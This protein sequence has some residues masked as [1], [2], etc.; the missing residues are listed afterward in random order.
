MIILIDSKNASDKFSTN[1]FYQSQ[2]IRRKREHPFL[3]K[4][5]PVPTAKIISKTFDALSY[6]EEQ[7]IFCYQDESSWELKKT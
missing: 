1:L 6:N 4:Q 5:K 7:E 2:K 3:K